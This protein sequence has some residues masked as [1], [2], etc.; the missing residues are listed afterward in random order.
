MGRLSQVAQRLSNPIKL[1][2]FDAGGRRRG[3]PLIRESYTSRKSRPLY[4]SNIVAVSAL[5]GLDRIPSID[6]SYYS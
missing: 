5:L 6:K 3:T 2:G 1:P 4:G